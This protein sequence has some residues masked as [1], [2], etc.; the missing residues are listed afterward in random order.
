[1]SKQ[2]LKMLNAYL[3]Y[4]GCVYESQIMKEFLKSDNTK[5]WVDVGAMLIE[6]QYRGM[7]SSYR[8][9]SGEK[10]WTHNRRELQ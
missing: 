5:E 4:N 10:V 3:Q 9:M 6:L 2:K 7:A 8:D 1:M